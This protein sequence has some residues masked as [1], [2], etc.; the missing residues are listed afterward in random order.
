WWCVPAHES[1][2]V[3]Q[4]LH[5]LMGA[6]RSDPACEGCTLSTEMGETIELCYLE[7][8]KSEDALRRQL[9]SPRF[10][11]FAELLERSTQPPRVEFTLASGIRGLDY[12]EEVLQGEST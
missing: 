5:M 6:T 10:K 12:A 1:T 4:A 2:F 7:K 3:I 9:R 11:K 8:W